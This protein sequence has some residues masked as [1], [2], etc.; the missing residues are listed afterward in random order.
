MGWWQHATWYHDE[1]FRVTLMTNMQIMTSVSLRK[2]FA[3]VILRRLLGCRA[4][5]L[6]Q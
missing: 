5:D 1:I 4:G 6:K 2:T 3:S